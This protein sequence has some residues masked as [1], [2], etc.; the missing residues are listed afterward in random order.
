[1]V[2]VPEDS[3]EAS[4]ILI[5]TQPIKQECWLLDDHPM[6]C[7]FCDGFDDY[8]GVMMIMIIPDILSLA[9]FG[10]N[11]LMR[12]DRNHPNKTATTV[13]TASH[14]IPIGMSGLVWEIC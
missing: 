8:W 4:I 5:H 6:L 13:R 9:Q 7:V 2:H 3:P 11:G 1:M 10:L 12:I 14:R